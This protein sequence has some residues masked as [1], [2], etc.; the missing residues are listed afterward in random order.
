MYR[1]C[2]V[3]NSLRFEAIAFVQVFEENLVLTPILTGM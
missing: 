3:G 2:F 1:E